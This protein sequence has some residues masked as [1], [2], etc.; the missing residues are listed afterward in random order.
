MENV[1]D[2]FA[3]RSWLTFSESEYFRHYKS[4]FFQETTKT[5]QTATPWVKL[6]IVVLIAKECITNS[7]EKKYTLLFTHPRKSFSS[8]LNT[9]SHFSKY[10][11]TLKFVKNTHKIKSVFYLEESKEASSYTINSI[12]L[13][14]YVF[15]S[16]TFDCGNW[17]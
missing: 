6:N 4:S 14:I 8:G 15:I 13:L 10:L 2:L 3:N 17:Y 7:F 12:S 9:N 5:W 1:T 16:N 11:E